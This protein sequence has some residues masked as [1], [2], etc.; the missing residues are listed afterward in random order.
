MDRQHIQTHL[1]ELLVKF[2]KLCSEQNIRYTLHG[3]TLL[4]AVRNGGF[5]PWDDDADVAMTR[6]EFR[7]LYDHLR[8]EGTD[9]YISGKI[10]TQFRCHDDPD[11][12]VDI[13][14]CDPISE[15]PFA[16]KLK[17]L[18]LTA[19]DIM[20]KNSSSKKLSNIHSYSLPKRIAFHFFYVLGLLIPMK[21]KAKWYNCVAQTWFNGSSKLIFR[22]NDQYVA[23][24]RIFPADWMNH[25]EEIRFE[26]KTFLTQCNYDG[27][28]ASCYGPDYMTP[29]QDSHA[30]QVHCLVRSD[31]ESI[32]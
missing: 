23:R 10:K 9:F 32:C 19:L 6:A 18:L 5:I 4:G 21:Q 30:Q 12:W 7:R 17:L 3:G 27:L 8:N 26:G 11:V 29:R 28:L 13:F 20:S 22:S 25:F 2:D 16:Q 1:L 15:H 31:L 14:I 24:R